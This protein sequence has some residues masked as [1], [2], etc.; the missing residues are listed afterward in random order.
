MQNVPSAAFD[1]IF[2]MHHCNI[3]RITAMWQTLHEGV[4]FENDVLAEREL[5]PFRGPKLDGEIDYFTSNDVRDW[6]RFGYQ[7]EILE[8]R[9]GET[10]VGRKRRI[11]E[12]I[13]KSYFS[14][15]QVLLKDEGH[16]FH[17]GSDIESFAARNDFEDYIIDVI[18]DRQVIPLTLLIALS[19]A[20]RV[21]KLCS[22]WRSLHDPFLPRCPGAS[23][24]VQRGDG[25]DNL[26]VTQARRDGLQLLDSL[27][28]KR[29]QHRIGHV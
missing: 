26:Q 10:E 13:D 7:Y 22:E 20:N 1:P 3:D 11:N 15:A 12:F 24:R 16:L 5:Y 17:D 18:Y 21:S 29:Q 25:Q 14:T 19:V 28:R 6:T 4:W 8:L 2:Y 9:D 23:A 27:A